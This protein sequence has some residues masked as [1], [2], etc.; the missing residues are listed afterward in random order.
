MSKQDLQKLIKKPKGKLFA[1]DLD[2]TLSIGD[3][4]GPQH[5]PEPKPN[6]KTIALCEEIVR[7]GGRIVIYTVRPPVWAKETVAWLHK[8]DVWHHGINFGGKP[9]ADVYIDDKALNVDDI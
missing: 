8:Y 1:F 2:G 5:S 9:G 6:R 4:W 7:K 3:Y